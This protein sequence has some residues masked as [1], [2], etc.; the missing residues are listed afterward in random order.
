MHF[1][2]YLI[3][4]GG[5]GLFVTAAGFVLYDIYLSFELEELLHRGEGDGEVE[6][7][8]IPAGRAV[9]LLKEVDSLQRPA[10]RRKA[11]RKLALKLSGTDAIVGAHH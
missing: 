10:T 11:R 1:L 5:F 2:E 6:G 7:H 4:F 8:D 3:L 9:Q